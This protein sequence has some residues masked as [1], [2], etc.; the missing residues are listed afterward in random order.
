MINFRKTNMS[1][2]FP[3]PIKKEVRIDKYRIILLDPAS[4]PDDSSYI[5][6][7]VFCIDDNDNIV[8]QVEKLE[9]NPLNLP[10]CFYHNIMYHD[11]KL[12]LFNACDLRVELDYKTGK[13][14]RAVEIR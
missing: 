8:W 13:I 11:N 1:I 7:N 2:T 10:N 9:H 12:K 4:I 6:R 14:L 5:N 3:F